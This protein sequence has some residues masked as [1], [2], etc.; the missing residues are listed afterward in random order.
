MMKKVTLEHL[1]LWEKGWKKEAFKNLN[2]LNS[3][4]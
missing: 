3:F 1:D 4:S 2:I